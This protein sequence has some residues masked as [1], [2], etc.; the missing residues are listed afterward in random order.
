MSCNSDKKVNTENDN[1][2]K[3]TALK[4][5]EGFEI[6]HYKNHKTLI[7]KKPY[8]G[9]TEKF[10]Y[11]LV[12]NKVDKNAIEIPLKNIVATSTTHIPMLELLGVE[13]KLIGFP[14]VN[15]I[16]SKRTRKR[17]DNK[18]IIDVGNPESMNVETLLNLKPSA[19]IGFSINSN[20]ELGNTLNKMNIPYLYNADWLE[21]T[22]LGRTEWIKFFGVLFDKEKEADSIFNQIESNYLEA[23]KI[24]AK[25]EKKP[26][27]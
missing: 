24:A 19:V 13:E 26:L 11:T 20:N 21:K 27:V 2:I 16:S 4:Y 5:A 18:Q 3:K 22:P 25:T 14:S 15:F 1:L 7:I 10:T 6:H 23:K 12:K 9:A 17:I 8:Q